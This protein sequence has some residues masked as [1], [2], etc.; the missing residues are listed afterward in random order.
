MQITPTE[1]NLALR[2]ADFATLAEALDYA[3]QGETGYNFYD[4]RGRLDT[5]LPY[6]QLRDEARDI[7]LRFNQLGLER[8][9]RIALIAHT[10]PDF[11]KIFFACQYAGLVPV[12]LPAT[13]FLGGRQA[14]EAQLRR[15]V[16]DCQAVA[17]MAAGDFM[18]FLH[19][20]VDGIGLQFVGQISDLPEHCGN[21]A[22]LHSPEVD[23]V[24]YLQYTSGS[25]RYPR[26]V[27]ITQKAVM[28]NLVAI[29]VE[30]V[31]IEVGDRCCSWL[32]F[33]HDMGLVGMVLAPMA[34][35]L[36]TDYLETRDFAMRPRLWLT[37]MSQNKSTISFGPPFG[38]E[39]CSRRLRDK[40]NSDLDLRAWRVAGVGAEMIRAETLAHFVE[41]M[42]VYGFNE[43]AFVPCY[44]M[45]ECSLAVSF[46]G[47]GEGCKTDA[48]AADSFST[49][50]RTTPVSEAGDSEAGDVGPRVSEF[51]VC[52]RPL[53]GFEIEVRDADNKPLP[54]RYC[55]T[56][57]VRSASVMTGYLGKEEE[58][59]E[60]L[61]ADGWL[62]TGDLA[63]R[64]GDELVITGR[65][66]DLIIINGRNI[67]PQDMEF[68]TEQQPEVRPGDASAF[69]ITSTD[70]CERAILVVQCRKLDQTTRSELALRLHSLIKEELGIEC[71]VELVPRH[72]LP[73]TTSGKLSRSGARK[74]FLERH[75]AERLDVSATLFSFPE[76]DE[77]AV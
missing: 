13:M 55:G 60:V 10:G 56:L 12:P 53:S 18:P 44:G 9:A 28:H 57:F 5:V 41:V 3:A 65:Q 42:Q 32:P 64:V 61:S 36:S 22:E 68:L 43:K 17:A 38:Y 74:D 15:L 33:Y 37:L 2:P 66:K 20:A 54:E 71:L 35:Q 50:S 45:A 16:V 11:M 4:G 14:F 62:N 59:R 76:L 21:Y 67:W 72:T 48:I 7:A 63:Y 25:T 39:L 23:E 73:R 34:S 27:V 75:P 51:V 24:A 8:G 49:G 46:A 6:T 58:T 29:V 52:G 26:G 40:P 19:A 70:G 47:L 1:N 31:K 30:G 69:S 77:Q